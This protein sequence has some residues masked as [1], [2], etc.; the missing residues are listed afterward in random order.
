MQNEILRPVL[1]TDETAIPRYDIVNPDGSVAQQNIELRLKNEVM[2]HGTPYDTE[3][4]L[5]ATLCE[6]LGLPSSAT[7]ANAFEAVIAKA[8][9]KISMNAP[10]EQDNSASGYSIGT[11][12]LRPKYTLYNLAYNKSVEDF[13][14]TA[15]VVTK[16]NQTVTA[17]GNGND[18]VISVSV[19]HGSNTGW[20]YCVVTPDATAV[21]ARVIAGA[22][23]IALTPGETN[24]I[25]HK[26]HGTSVTFEA[27]Y[28]TANA[29]NNSVTTIN[30]LTVIDEVST[31][32][33]LEEAYRDVTDSDIFASVL[34]NAPFNSHIVATSNWQ[35]IKDGVW[36]HIGALPQLIVSAI[37][38]VSVACIKDNVRLN[39]TSIEESVTFDIPE[40]GTWSVVVND[41]PVGTVD[42]TTE[43]VYNFVAVNKASA[44][45]SYLALVGNVNE[46][47]V[48]ASLGKNNEGI[49]SGIGLALAMLARFL[50]TSL[51]VNTDFYH[52]IAQSTLTDI[53]MS[54]KS[55]YEIAKVN[56]LWD[57][58]IAIPYVQSTLIDVKASISGSNSATITLTENHINGNIPGVIKLDT[59]RKGPTSVSSCYININ[60]VRVLDNTTASV[61]KV[62]TK[63]VLA[64]YNITAPGSYT[65]ECYA[66]TSDGRYPASASINIT[67]FKEV[68]NK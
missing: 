39:A 22:T 48:A 17:T 32:S 58:L 11:T 13:I 36:N 50:N 44:Q 60:G 26:F 8:G 23:D 55:Q 66:Y 28:E 3:S 33:Q 5:P 65:V 56:A 14:A 10:T 34:N 2:Q 30:N 9:A 20:L 61:R 38:G 53:L 40:Y 57:F 1:E 49:V 31:L 45:S 19:N 46:N 25:Q 62:I 15:C 63:E 21:S 68:N 7:P 29:A 4:V 42:I 41:E 16:D 67:F 35:H 52:L 18:K 64:S 43:K 24:I 54:S 12:W 59:Y 27:T 6:K 37:S 47:M 51:N